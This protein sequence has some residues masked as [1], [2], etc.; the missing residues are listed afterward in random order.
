MIPHQ[1]WST[2]LCTVTDRELIPSSILEH[3][4]GFTVEFLK[5]LILRLLF[6][7]LFHLCSLSLWPYIIYTFIYSFFWYN[8]CSLALS[9][10]AALPSYVF[11]AGG[12]KEN[13]ALGWKP[14]SAL[15]LQSEDTSG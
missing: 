12:Q 7:S 14:L 6:F 4:R 3:T 1:P 10:S 15:C 5:V 11:V 2:P 9:Q 13:S 8:W